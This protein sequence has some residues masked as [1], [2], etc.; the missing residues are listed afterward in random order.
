MKSGRKLVRAVSET[1]EQFR[2]LVQG[3]KDYAIY[4]LDTE[5]RV[6]SWNAGAE[7]IKG[8][9]AG[10]IIG[11]HFS[12][13]Y[14]DEDVK[15]GKPQRAL[16]TALRE[17]KFE[18]ETVR[19]RK[20]GT[21]FWAHVVIDPIYDEQGTH[22]G[23]AKIT[24]DVTEKHKTEE[25]LAQA[26]V[27][28]V[29]SQK[30]EAVG[31]LTGGIAHDFNNLL[32]AVIGSL[33]IVR[34]RVPDDPKITRLL[35]NAIQGAQ[36]GATLTQRML[37]FARR[38]DLKVAA[39]DL[40]DLV[41]GMSQLLGASIGSAIQIETHFPLN[42][43]P[44]KGDAN[45]LELALLNL[46][47]NARDAMPEGGRIIIFGR[48]EIVMPPNVL[49]LESGQYVCL[50]VADTGLGMDEGTLARATEPF[51]TTK[52]VGRGTGLGLSMVL[53][54]AEQSGGQLMLHSRKGEGTTAEMWLPVAPA[55]LLASSE[56]DSET[57]PL[58]PVAPVT[59]LV[60]DDDP[61]V[62]MNTAAML[63]DLGHQVLEASSGAQALRVLRR[64]H[65]DVVITDQ[66]MPN[67]T[68]T[69]LIDAMKAEW[70]HLPVILATGYAE[71]PSGT[72]P[73]LAKLAK[74]YRQEMLARIIAEQSSAN[75]SETVLR[76]RSRPKPEQRAG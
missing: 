3:V 56:L 58:A 2:L 35:D 64:S 70:P 34:R 12:R 17:G 59:V 66:V 73:A 23:F 28:L 24:R 67:M 14:V 50:S 9:T 31:Q 76:F 11:E 4:M 53:G 6:A 69:E 72:D 74:P 68:G 62:L 18:T 75:Q 26:R 16:E 55:D 43:P 19:Q 27:R 36:R 47:V 54:V 63:D 7:R 46:V 25:E 65:V 37:A 44:A 21:H 52:G 42:L 61:L 1:E 39:I 29:Q 51:F 32:T 30:M 33:S 49:G 5:G 48:P 71:L 22:I 10:E 38:Q 45:Q 57:E 8:Y 41:H 13:F 20:D 40:Q 15:A 60:V